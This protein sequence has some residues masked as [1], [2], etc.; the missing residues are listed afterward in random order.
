MKMTD[1]FEVLSQNIE[2]VIPENGLKK[3]L[4]TAKNEKRQL[5]IKLGADP[6]AP[7]IHFGHLVVL[8]KLKEFQELG[9]KVIFII[10]DFTG[11]IG[12]PTGK[13]ETRKRLD[14]ET[15]KKNADTYAKQVFKILDKE[16]TQ[17][18]FNSEWFEK[19]SIYD[20]LA[21]SSKY[22]VARMLERND[23]QKRYS[24]N[25]PISIL[26]FLYPLVQG[27]D[28]VEIKADIELGGTDQ[29]FN[30]LVG[31]TL[32][33]RYEQEPQIAMVMPIIEGLDG[34][35]KMSKSLGNYIGLND[36]PNDM[37]GKIMSI[38]DEIL[39]K[40]IKLLSFRSP[41]E[42][43]KILSQLKEGVIN[44]RDIKM[45]FG[46]EMVSFLYNEELGKSA[47]SNFITQFV[48]KDIPNDI[49][50]TLIDSGKAIDIIQSLDNTLSK[51]EIK[52]LI[53]QNA[54]KFNNE[55][56]KDGFDNISE[57]GILKIGKR[58]IFK[59]KIK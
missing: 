47:K 50:T 33:E 46:E 31:R 22:T 43:D 17:I 1:D 36:E 7:D 58:K 44:P 39:P 27:Y 19:I 20:F 40:Y 53:K 16:K 23:F 18:R 34:K 28:S 35:Q 5:I 12:D 49:R 52:R 42:K 32:Q 51:G 6:S 57:N 2:K 21:L 13:N 41:D 30:L 25:K 55:I 48:K 15:V 54:V 37:F 9:H 3:K 45:D 56:I 4:E 29:E 38:P 14:K 26:E 59:L 10:G 8:K 24:G 11:M